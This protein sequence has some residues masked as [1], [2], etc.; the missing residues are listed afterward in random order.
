VHPAFQGHTH[1][2]FIRT[3]RKSSRIFPAYV[4]SLNCARHS[5]HLSSI[6]EVINRRFFRKPQK[7]GFLLEAAAFTDTRLS[8]TD[9][10]CKI[11]FVRSQ[12]SCR[13][14]WAFYWS[15]YKWL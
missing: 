11:F 1:Q 5:G 10:S 8:F 15:V 7:S 2:K 12:P 14:P 3:H 4:I 9:R 6:G 13:V